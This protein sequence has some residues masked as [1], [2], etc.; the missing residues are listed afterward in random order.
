VIG[1]DAAEVY[2]MIDSLG[3][4]GAVIGH[5]RSESLAINCWSLQPLGAIS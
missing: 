5:A 3:D 4:V 2:A 1:L